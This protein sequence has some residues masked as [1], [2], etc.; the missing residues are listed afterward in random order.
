M[1]RTDF[2]FQIENGTTGETL[3]FANEFPFGDLDEF[4]DIVDTMVDEPNQDV[5]ELV[6]TGMS[7]ILWLGA[8]ISEHTAEWIGEVGFDAKVPVT[9]RTTTKDGRTL[10]VVS[11]DLG[12]DR[13]DGNLCVAVN[14]EELRNV[15]LA[16]AEAQ[17][18]G[19]TD[20]LDDALTKA[21]P[22]YPEQ[23]RM[24]MDMPEKMLK[25]VVG[26]TNLGLIG[27]GMVIRGQAGEDL[28]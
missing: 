10:F 20:V 26:V 6:V 5:Y 15:S 7:P 14:Q 11:T 25:Q 17:Q 1:D 18:S 12:V 9:A 22:Q 21:F 27:L 23:Q 24:W 16:A 19:D 2:S 13:I 3:T 8:M 28:D 4:F